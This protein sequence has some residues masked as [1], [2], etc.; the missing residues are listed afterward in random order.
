MSENEVLELTAPHVVSIDSKR[1]W[2]CS[3]Q[4]KVCGVGFGC[5]NFVDMLGI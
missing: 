2:W 4:E 3:V 1:T 5:Y